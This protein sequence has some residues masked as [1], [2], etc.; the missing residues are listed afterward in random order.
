MP[1]N[2]SFRQAAVST[3]RPRWTD[4]SRNGS[5]TGFCAT[6]GRC[7][8]SAAQTFIGYD[9]LHWGDDT[10]HQI[11]DI[12]DYPLGI[13][14]KIRRWFELDADGVFDHWGGYPEDIS[15]NSVACR[16]FFTNPLADPEVVCRSIAVRQF[17]EAAGVHAFDAW[18]ALE[19][20]HAILS[21]ACTY[22]PPQWPGW[23]PGRE[24]VP[25]PEGFAKRGVQ[26]GQ[27]EVQANGFTYNPQEAA[28][29]LEAV[30]TAWEAAYPHY[31]LASE[32]LA[33]AVEAADDTPV[34]YSFWWSGEKATPTRKEHLRRERLYVDSMGFA[35]R[36]IGLHFGL[37]ALYERVKRDATAYQAQSRE[38][39]TRDARA[40]RDAADFFER[41][42]RDGDDKLK[43]RD[44]VALYRAKADGI[45]AYLSGAG[46]KP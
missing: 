9:D 13:G 24:F 44:W 12:Q 23:Y 6:R 1:T 19:R 14:A 16:A 15:C 29:R 21:N 3:W 46:E 17:G 45:D 18:K 40:C 20:A 35:G 5:R 31:R 7:A 38:L 27:P 34:F 30:A 11:R 8:E 37:N 36:E 28:E 42:Q 32:A 33:K 4:G 26:G 22:A 2:G 25:T 41:I 43:S 39:L 10:V